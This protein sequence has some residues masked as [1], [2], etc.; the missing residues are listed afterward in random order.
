LGAA[1]TVAVAVR[2]WSVSIELLYT[3][4]VGRFIHSPAPGGAEAASGDRL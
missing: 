4:G 1:L 2:L 3:L